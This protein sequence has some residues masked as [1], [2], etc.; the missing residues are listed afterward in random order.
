MNFQT[1]NGPPVM[2]TNGTDRHD[3]LQRGDII[4]SVNFIRMCQIHSEVYHTRINA[5]GGSSFR[6]RPSRPSTSVPAKTPSSASNPTG[7][8]SPP[9]VT[10]TGPSPVSRGRPARCGVLRRANPRP[11]RRGRT[12]LTSFSTPWPRSRCDVA[13]R[14][15]PCQDRSRLGLDFNHQPGR[16]RRQGRRTWYQFGWSD[17][18]VGRTPGPRRAVHIRWCRPFGITAVRDAVRRVLAWGSGTP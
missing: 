1:Q 8:K 17:G 12:W 10:P 18:Q 5:Q 4:T 11:P 14:G 16:G 3:H 6:P 13:N 2:A 9:A 15:G 7:S